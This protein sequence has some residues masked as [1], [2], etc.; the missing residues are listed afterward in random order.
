M[1]KSEF[2]SEK[3]A[4]KSSRASQPLK[5]DFKGEAITTLENGFSF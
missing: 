5:N 3:R 1:G 2:S 4:K